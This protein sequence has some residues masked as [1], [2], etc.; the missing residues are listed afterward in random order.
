MR[1]LKPDPKLA[2]KLAES[3]CFML[4]ILVNNVDW[5]LNERITARIE[6]WLRSKAVNVIIARHQSDK[7]DLDLAC[8]LQCAKSI[9]QAPLTQNLRARCIKPCFPEADVGGRAIHVQAK[10]IEH[11]DEA[12]FQ[13]LRALWSTPPWSMVFAGSGRAA[14]RPAG[15]RSPPSLTFS[16]VNSQFVCK[17]CSRLIASLVLQAWEDRRDSPVANERA[18]V[19]WFQ[20]VPML[21]R[22]Q[23]HRPTL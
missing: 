6:E 19:M 3:S 10:P 9:Q 15:S 13:R 1:I 8:A 20:A 11:L 4:N 2:A 21:Q 7:P 14:G 18:L 17:T 16:S 5:I 12:G 22:P 23:H